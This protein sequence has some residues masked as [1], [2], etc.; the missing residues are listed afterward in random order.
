MSMTE[1][2]LARTSARS[3]FRSASSRLR[4]NAGIDR[5]DAASAVVGFAEVGAAARRLRASNQFNRPAA[6][7]CAPVEE[8]PII[9][10]LRTPVVI[11]LDAQIECRDLAA[12]IDGDWRR[13]SLVERGAHLLANCY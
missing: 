13:S 2:S 8:A 11:D 9:I 6:F 1:L 7:T 5:S 12:T 3:E 4:V 10:N